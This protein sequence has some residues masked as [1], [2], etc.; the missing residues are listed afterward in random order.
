MREEAD[1][2]ESKFGGVTFTG[3]YFSASVRTD[4]VEQT[5][6][7]TGRSCTMAD[8]MSRR[9]S[10]RPT[11]S[12]RSGRWPGRRS[13]PFA[14][15]HCLCRRQSNKHQQWP[16]TVVQRSPPPSSRPVYACLLALFQLRLLSSTLFYSSECVLDKKAS[17]GGKQVDYS[18]CMRLF[19]TQHARV[20]RLFV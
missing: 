15:L 16:L 3:L 12:E 4:H 10:P 9:P 19:R 7:N 11:G 6:A 5:S 14:A 18:S 8:R 17:G 1:A 13:Q 20:C 2:A